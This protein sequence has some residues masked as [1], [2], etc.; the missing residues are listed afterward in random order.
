VGQ[1]R[2]I[3]SENEFKCKFCTPV[4]LFPFSL[5]S[6]TLPLTVKLT[7]AMVLTK[8]KFKFELFE[9]WFTRN[10]ICTVAFIFPVE[11]RSPRERGN[12]K[13]RGGERRE[14][15]T[16]REKEMMRER[17]EGAKG[18]FSLLHS[19]EGFVTLKYCNSTAIRRN[20]ERRDPIA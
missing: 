10:P 18:G 20:R 19:S 9:N 6:P 15:E 13:K 3:L 4:Y 5:L 7:E 8:V 16:R 12:E 14:K 1:Q 17:R 2:Q 11:N